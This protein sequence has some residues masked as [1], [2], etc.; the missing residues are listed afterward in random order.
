MKHQFKPAVLASAIAVTLALGG[1]GSDQEQPEI[2]DVFEE[3]GL[4]CKLPD[5]VQIA[6]PDSYPISALEQAELDAAK[7]V[8]KMAAQAEAG[9]SW[10]EAEWDA[11][12][13]YEDLDLYSVLG[14]TLE[15]QERQATAKAE[16]LAFQIAQGQDVIRG[17]GFDE[18][19]EA[20]FATVPPAS[21]LGASQ[22]LNR[23]ENATTPDM[24][25]SEICYTPP[26]SC[27]NY[28]VA[29]ESGTYDCVIPEINIIED[30]PAPDYIAQSGEAVAYYRD[31]NHVEGADNTALYENIV[32]HTWNNDDCTAYADDSLS[33]QWG[34][35]AADQAGIDDNYGVYWKL[36]LADGHS[37]CANIIF[38]DTKGSK[39]ISENDL[40][41]PVGP[42]GNVTLHNLDKNAYADDNFP[43]NVLD[44]QLII[45][46]HPFFGAE[47]SSGIAS[48]GWSQAPNAEGICVGEEL[49]CPED[50]VAVGVGAEE[51]ASKCV[52]TFAPDE[53]SLLL[54]GGFNGWGDANDANF[55]ASQ[56]EYTGEGQYRVNY[57]YSDDECEIVEPVE[58][59]DDTEAVAGE[60][61]ASSYD[62]KVAD[63]DWSEPTTFGSVKGGD[64]SSVGATITMTV[65]E[66]VGQNMKVDMV[67]DKTYQF[68]VNA[69][70]VKAVELTIKEVPLS[71]FPV[72]TLGGAETELKYTTNGQY[73]ARLA[74]AAETHV[75]TISDIAAGFALGAVGTDNEVT[76]NMPLPLEAGDAALSFTSQAAEYDFILNVA[77]MTAPTIEIK[78]ALPFGSDAVYI[79]GSV[80]GWAAPAGDEVIWNAD[81]RSYSV[82]YGLEA[83]G[84]HA[85]KFADAN[86]GP[87]N[88]GFNEVTVSGAE[89]TETVTDAGGN[90]QVVVAKSTTYKFEV[91]YA[92]ADPVVTV[93]EAPIYLRGGFTDWGASETNQLGFMA[94]DDAN[95]AEASHI[96]SLEVDYPGGASSFKIADEG[97]GG[98][99]G[100]NYGTAADDVQLELGVPLTLYSANS[101][102]SIGDSKNINVTLDA[103][104]YIFAFE[105]GVTKIMTVTSK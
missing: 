81:S 89:G 30:A 7:N 16:A 31:E 37:S 3:T 98:T 19:F 39:R 62:F 49:I 86:W 80:N 72:L 48:C 69:S 4:W 20:W 55:A 50:T 100:Y 21:Y 34:V 38:N 88:L 40:I 32:V 45:N 2:I 29:D 84:N 11:D 53:T 61:C 27:P 83:D 18:W 71:A 93:S 26:L 15:E 91:S 85:F 6:S 24:D 52:A 17:E 67:K 35:S 94:M 1:C 12:F 77:D 54:R 65:G 8:A 33:P 96:Y 76:A 64:Q 75:F 102:E 99:L 82:I 74:L 97:W 36:N 70:D 78:P 63:I 41:M 66:G 43:P 104:T 51:I 92:T 87:V 90:M 73:V 14:L 79:R 59:T 9:D 47:A 42:S 57:A 13:E 28:K 103:G 60:D 101:D 25:G 5:I 10:D 56:L 23:A 44:G 68:L 46:Q 22:R 58:A 105:D 95:T